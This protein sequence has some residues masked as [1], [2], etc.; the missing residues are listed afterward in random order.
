[1]LIVL[2]QVA[3]VDTAEAKVRLSPYSVVHI[4]TSLPG[5]YGGGGYGGASGG[6]GGGGGYQQGGYGQQQG[7]YGGGY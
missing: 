5:G 1:M 7:G 6:Y 2:L 4:L 3:E